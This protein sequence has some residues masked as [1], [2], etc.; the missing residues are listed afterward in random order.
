MR[1]LNAICGINAFMIRHCGKNLQDLGCCGTSLALLDARRICHPRW[2]LPV[3]ENNFFQYT[4]FDIF[5]AVMWDFQRFLAVI[6]P[7]SCRLPPMSPAPGIMFFFLMLG[8]P[9]PDN[10]KK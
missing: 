5:Y 7:D 9:V 10:F 4:V 8:L 3:K 6:L 2:S 1:D